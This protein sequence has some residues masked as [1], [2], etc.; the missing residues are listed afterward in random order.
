MNESSKDWAFL[1]TLTILYVED[2]PATREEVGEFLQRRAGA[3]II[4][5]DGAEG[6]AA[7]QSGPVQMIVT[8]IQMPAMNGLAMARKIRALDPSVPIII[9]TAFEQPDF[10]M[11]SIE[12]G[13]DQY[14]LKPIRGERLEFSLLTCAHRLQAEAQLRRQQQR[15]AEAL[16]NHHQMALSILFR[17]LAQ[18]FHHLLGGILE[19]LYL[20]SRMDPAGE[21]GRVL[22]GFSTKLDRASALGS[23]L[24]L[25]ADPSGPRVPL[26]SLDSLIRSTVEETLAG[27]GTA[28]SFDFQRSAAAV[29]ASEAALAQVFQS[30]AQ[31]AREAM[32]SG[33]T[34]HVST[35]SWDAGDSEGP[36]S[37]PDRY[38]RIRFRD[39]GPGIPQENLGMVFEPYFSTKDHGLQDGNGLGLSLCEAIVRAHGGSIS[40]DSQP[41]RGTT[42]QVQL[43]LEMDR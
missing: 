27:S 11:G 26:P 16:R 25:L 1:K 7:F 39:T 28:A 2:D 43:P 30:L 13:V 8:D 18:D 36:G 5:A 19:P 41:N 17:D 32:A 37:L 21:V 10:L 42:I 4:A 20:E 35:E 6:L 24:L 34:L 3:V 12:L 40:V 31:N 14:V 22:R 9:T 23:R 15:E 29:R 33:G 38:L